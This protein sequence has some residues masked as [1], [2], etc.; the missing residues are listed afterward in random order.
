MPRNPSARLG[1][2]GCDLRLQARLGLPSRRQASGLRTRLSSTR[3]LIKRASENGVVVNVA[4]ATG[5]M[6]GAFVID[7]DP[8][9]GGFATLSALER[10]HGP[11][12]R[13]AVV[14]TGGGGLH[15]FFQYPAKGAS[16]ASGGNCSAPASI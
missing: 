7:V 6:S 1:Q 4:I 12:P 13:D 11:F 14:I 9:N 16:I 5:A 3:H 8:R 10:D 15:L 2:Q